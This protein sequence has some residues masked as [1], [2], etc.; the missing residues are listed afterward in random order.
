[1]KKI[2]FI[3]Y[4]FTKGGGAERL[5]A[6]IVNH[7]NPNK[8]D[9]SVIE[10]EH[11]YVKVEP[12]NDNVKILSPLCKV[13]DAR[14]REVIHDLYYDPQKV[15]DKYI[16]SDYDL[17][18]SF[19]Y[20]MPSFLLPENRHTI[21]WIHTCIYDLLGKEAERYYNLQQR[22]FEK[23]ERIVSI[24][25]ITTQ[26]IVD[27]YPNQKNKIVEIYN[28]LDID[29]VQNKSKE[30]TDIL[31]E[32][33]SIVYVGRLEE[34]KNPERLFRI[35]LNLHK[36]GKRY[37]LYYLGY[38]PLE[39]EL[40]RMTNENGLNDYVHFVG[41]VENP[42]PVI[43][44]ARV[45][46]M[47]SNEE[48]FPMSLL[49]AQALGIPFVSTPVGGA[50]ILALDSLCGTVFDKDTEAERAITYYIETCDR[51]EIKERCLKSIE[52]FRLEAYIHKIESLFDQLLDEKV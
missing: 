38:G 44:Q 6:S 11:D 36:G 26:S 25:D 42:F 34:R 9:I 35:V 40:R 21:A 14:P 3:I 49:E 20:Q 48:G 22:V 46:V 4:S 43:N 15:F 5:L 18:V 27:L 50:R 39:D 8:Y 31:L 30:Q 29:A 41:Y 45:C 10:V 13:D 51:A 2:I 52:R 12:T 16:G 47:T 33:N 19:N 23:A 7:L 17:Y 24:S 1:M 32:E 28:G 37:H